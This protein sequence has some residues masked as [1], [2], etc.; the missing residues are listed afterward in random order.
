M[1][2]FPNIFQCLSTAELQP[3]SKILYFRLKHT[4]LPFLSSCYRAQ[5]FIS[6]KPVGFTCE[7]RMGWNEGCITSES[8]KH[9]R[10]EQENDCLRHLFRTLHGL[11]VSSSFADIYQ[12][13]LTIILFVVENK[14]IGVGK[15]V[16]SRA[17]SYVWNEG[18]GWW[19]GITYQ[20]SLNHASLMTLR[21]L[22]T[23][24]LSNLQRD[25][26]TCDNVRVFWKD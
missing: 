19:E 23:H 18:G 14:W 16:M 5:L 17:E 21:I 1:K 7:G 6:T 12:G 13:Q 2:Q 4:F 20:G 11:W 3:C 22:F 26:K 9:N 8:M 15:D 10:I 24:T 25:L